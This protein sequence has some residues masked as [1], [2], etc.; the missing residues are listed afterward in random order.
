M[1]VR[2]A[3]SASSREGFGTIGCGADRTWSDRGLSD[4]GDFGQGLTTASIRGLSVRPAQR[5]G[6]SPG[7]PHQ[8]YALWEIPPMRADRTPHSLFTWLRA[9]GEAFPPGNRVSCSRRPASPYIFVR[10]GRAI[11]GSAEST[12]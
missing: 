5:P 9:G 1:R 7:R 12:E 8:T 11:K 4:R 3:A 10:T 2:T 6:V